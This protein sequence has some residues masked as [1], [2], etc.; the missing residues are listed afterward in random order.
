MSIKGKYGDEFE[1]L[2]INWNADF[3]KLEDMIGNAG[4]DPA[5]AYDEVISALRRHR[6]ELKAG[7][8]E[9]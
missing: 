1:S 7:L 5:V 4:A 2:L 6:H 3:D 9:N 8:N